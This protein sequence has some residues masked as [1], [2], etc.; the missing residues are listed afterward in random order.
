MTEATSWKRCSTCKAPIAHGAGYYRCSVST[1]NSK[2][3]GLFFCSVPCWEAH[4][5]GARHKDAW[6]EEERAPAL[7]EE[8]APERAASPHAEPARRR[9]VAAGSPATAATAAD[10]P[11]AS[12]LP[13]DVLIVASK[14]KQYVKARSGMNTSDRVF[15]VLSEHL[16]QLATRAIRKAAQ[17]ERRTV[18]DRDIAAV[19]KE[20]G[21]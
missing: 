5:P 6:A 14:L 19:L 2:R 7:G 4:V 1:C 21:L 15:G 13:R 16:R 8:T 12:A 11:E 9:V 10:A 20:L 3:V 17:E 18:L